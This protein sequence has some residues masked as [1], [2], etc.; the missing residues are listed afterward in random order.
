MCKECYEKSINATIHNDEKEKIQSQNS[1][2]KIL[3]IFKE[4]CSKETIKTTAI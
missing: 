3:T 2:T 4:K 1:Y